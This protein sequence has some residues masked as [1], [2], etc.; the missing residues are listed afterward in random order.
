M[1]MKAN[2]TLLLMGCV[3]VLA[4]LC[5]LSVDAPMRFQRQRQEREAVVK[6]RLLTIRAAE[7]KYRVRHG[8]YAG[9]FAELAKG[10]LLADSISYI[11]FSSKKRFSLQISS[12]VGKS[13]RQVPLMECGA[14]YADYLNGLDESSV[15]SLTD[16]ANAAGRY[17]GLKIGDLETPNDNAGNWE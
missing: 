13:G 14:E 16:E 6:Q 2:N 15:A 9:S 12:T 11:P 5:F 3:L 4:A 7:E 8:A 10:G 1:K 17:P